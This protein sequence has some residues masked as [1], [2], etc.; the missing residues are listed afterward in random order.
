MIITRKRV[1]SH[2]IKLELNYLSPVDNQRLESSGTNY[3]KG[4]INRTDYCLMSIL[5]KRHDN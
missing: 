5:K 1:K 3:D 4:S 2:I